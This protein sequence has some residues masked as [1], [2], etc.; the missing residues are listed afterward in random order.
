MKTVVQ[1]LIVNFPQIPPNTASLT[2]ETSNALGTFQ[3]T[4]KWLNG[5]WNGWATLPSGEIRPFGCIPDVISWVDFM[6]FGV[7][8]DS[9]LPVIALNNLVG[10]TTLYLLQW[11]ID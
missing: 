6:D 1:S 4:F 7:F 5:I 9:P 8:I 2:F 10:I 3:F 11:G